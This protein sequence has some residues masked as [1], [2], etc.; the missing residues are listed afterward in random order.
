MLKCTDLQATNYHVSQ[1]TTF[2]IVFVCVQISRF[3]IQYLLGFTK[4]HSVIL[5][6][7]TGQLMHTWKS[8][9]RFESLGEE[10]TLLLL[11][12]IC[13]LPFDVPCSPR[14]RSRTSV[15]MCTLAHA[16]VSRLGFPHRHDAAVPL[17]SSSGRLGEVRE[18]YRAGR[19]YWKPGGNHA[20]TWGRIILW[21]FVF[22]QFMFMS[23]LLLSN[24]IVGLCPHKTQQAIG[25]LYSF[26]KDLLGPCMTRKCLLLARPASH[27]PVIVPGNSNCMPFGFQL[28]SHSCSCSVAIRRS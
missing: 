24:G 16:A 19:R 26:I 7:A 22:E 23:S 11:N 6:M 27:D 13:V 8:F 2:S 5:S 1:N 12:K 25:L 21:F 14:P 3:S 17:V 28:L 18:L 20:H 9:I 15:I 10:L 4:H